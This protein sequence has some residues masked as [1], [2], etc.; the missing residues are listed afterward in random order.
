V[1]ETIGLL[2]KK[3]P[4][5]LMD[6]VIREAFQSGVLSVVIDLGELAAAAI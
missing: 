1:S 4:K 2:G 5:E 6:R 3:T